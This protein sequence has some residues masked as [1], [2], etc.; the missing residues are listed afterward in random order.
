MALFFFFFL[1]V[2]TRLSGFLSY[3]HPLRLYC[4]ILEGSPVV[5]DVCPK[6]S[7]A[8][9]GGGARGPDSQVLGL[10]L[11]TIQIRATAATWVKISSP[12]G[13]RGEAESIVELAFPAIHN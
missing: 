6:P 1:L 7:P 11:M 4:L 13:P 5:K 12:A 2:F 3:T 9:A 8:P 10:M